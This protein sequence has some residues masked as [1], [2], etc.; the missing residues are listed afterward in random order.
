MI[1]LDYLVQSVGLQR[2]EKS[3]RRK[4]DKKSECQTIEYEWNWRSH[5]VKQN[6]PN[7]E[8]RYFILSITC[9]I[10]SFIFVYM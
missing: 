3:E 2:T 1:I 10:Y 9:Y 4:R 8:D 6:K 7:S 5:Y